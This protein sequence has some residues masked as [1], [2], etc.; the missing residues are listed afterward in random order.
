ML[1]LLETGIDRSHDDPIVVDFLEAADAARAGEVW[2]WIKSAEQDLDLKKAGR[3][4]LL[5]MPSS[6]FPANC[7][8][9]L[10][11]ETRSRMGVSVDSKVN[12]EKAAGYLGLPELQV[13]NRNSLP[14]QQVKAAIGWS[15]SS[16]PTVAGPFPG[17]LDSKRFWI[18][19]GLF[20]A[21]WGCDSGP[22]LVT[23]A[24]TWHQQASRAFA[25]EL[26]APQAA[27]IADWGASADDEDQSISSLAV[28]FG[29]G[30][31]VIIHQ[32]ENAGVRF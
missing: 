23:E 15:G 6:P 21:A 24:N 17:T 16:A 22:R 1:Q 27:L 10:A 13:R 2:D 30:T 9:E 11:R 7:G 12:P 4:P 31:K 8:Y 29:V 28:K 20:L 25:A 26:L 5:Q 19:R 32:L 14:R 3:E 18:A